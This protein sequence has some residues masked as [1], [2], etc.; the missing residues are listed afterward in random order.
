M[1]SD[2]NNNTG[3]GLGHYLKQSWAISRTSTKAYK[4]TMLTLFICSVV[5]NFSIM[6]S[7]HHS[8]ENERQAFLLS[9]FF[10][11]LFTLLLCHYLVRPYLRLKVIGDSLNLKVLLRM[12]L[13]FLVCG[14]LYYALNILMTEFGPMQGAE[15]KRLQIVT[16]DG[17]VDATM[18]KAELW[19]IGSINSA[20]FFAGWSVAYM[21][22]HQL[23]ARKELQ[24]QV[25]K[26]QM[27]QLT[28]QLSPHFLFNTFN[29]IRALVYEDQD[30]AADTVT[31]LSELFRIHMQAH[32]RTES[33]LEEEWQVAKR[34]LGIEQIRLEE[35]LQ[36]QTDFDPTLMQENLP[37][38][39]LL[40]FIENAIKHGISPSSS[41]GI[42]KITSTAINDESWQLH[43]SNSY[44]PGM[45]IGG[46]KVGLKNVNR[47]L[48]LTYQNRYQLNKTARNNVFAID[49]TLPRT[50]KGPKA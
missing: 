49:L 45:N 16:E 27:Q 13:F 35:R 7:L 31:E 11:P 41:P 5:M 15:V 43:V 18:G 4:I 39:T 23:Q 40:T 50:P 32:L 44:K 34:Y 26:A 42:I 47:R 46:T 19:V 14:I 6:Q 22:W 48:K 1:H 33:S 21:L 24:L 12:L 37:T 30:K 38:L 2:T 10:E 25:Q 8:S 9:S 17:A 28:N 36:L 20:V 29:S 3:K